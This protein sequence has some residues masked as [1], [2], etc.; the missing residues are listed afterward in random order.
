MQALVYCACCAVLCCAVLCCA[1]LCTV[2]GRLPNLRLAMVHTCH[3]MLAAVFLS[4]GKDH[5]VCH[6]VAQA[7]KELSC[8]VRGAPLV[9]CTQAHH[10]HVTGPVQHATGLELVPMSSGAAAQAA[11]DGPKCT[12]DDAP[13]LHSNKPRRHTLACAACMASRIASS[14]AKG[15]CRRRVGA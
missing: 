9:V 14:A 11:P 10:R 4:S 13:H 7:M 2:H 12:G 8:Q 5:M 1:V 6:G 3:E 15:A